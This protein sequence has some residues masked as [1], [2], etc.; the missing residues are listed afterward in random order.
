M[1]VWEQRVQ[2]W[3]CKELKWRSSAPGWELGWGALSH[4]APFARNSLSSCPSH[5]LNSHLKSWPVFKCYIIYSIFLISPTRCGFPFLEVFT[6]LH[7]HFSYIDGH[8]QFLA[9]LLFAS[10]HFKFSES[11]DQ[12]IFK[13]FLWLPVPCFI[14]SICSTN[15]CQMNQLINTLKGSCP[16]PKHLFR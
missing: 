15:I 2:M 7:L 11:M 5:Y 1:I 6:A 3:K 13:H 8:I 10:P 12:V 4:S 16:F 14:N 9:L